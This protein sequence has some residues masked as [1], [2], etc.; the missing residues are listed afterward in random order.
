M[1]I[2]KWLLWLVLFVVVIGGGAA[3]FLVITVD[4][5]DLKPQISERVESATGRTLTLGGDL[6][7]Q[8]YPW[9]GVT[10][11]DFALSNRP[12]FEPAHMLKADKVDVQVKLMP[13][14]SKQLE[15]SVNSH[16]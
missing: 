9:V 7:W 11:N 13:L 6:S 14:L 3:I 15:V 1:K 10:I 4:P 12:G 5:N 8:F 16:N 2:I